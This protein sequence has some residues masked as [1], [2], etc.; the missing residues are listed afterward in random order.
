MIVERQRDISKNY[1][2][3]FSIF[4]LEK[5]F[6]EVEEDQLLRVS[7]LNV[8]THFASHKG[9]VVILYHDMYCPKS[10]LSYSDLFFIS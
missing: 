7:T 10:P 4:S 2:D 5:N 6:F 3:V 9:C 1:L 8:L